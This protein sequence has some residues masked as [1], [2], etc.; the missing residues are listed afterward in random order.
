MSHEDAARVRHCQPRVH[1]IWMSDSLRPC[2]ICV[3][4]HLC[5]GRRDRV[6]REIFVDQ[7]I[8]SYSFLSFFYYTGKFYLK[9]NLIFHRKKV[10]L[11]SVLYMPVICQYLRRLTQQSVKCR[12]IQL[13]VYCLCQRALV[14]TIKAAARNMGVIY[15]SE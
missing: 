10:V 7:Q 3:V 13:C 2:I 5:D 14:N 1:H 11:R 15:S 12:T 8:Y 4:L 9:Y 6:A